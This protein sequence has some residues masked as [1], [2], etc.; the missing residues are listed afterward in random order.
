MELP[1]TLISPSG[2]VEV[3]TTF[4]RANNLMLSHGYKVKP[5]GKPEQAKPVEPA[6]P[7]AKPEVSEK[8][9]SDTRPSALV[10]DDAPQAR[11]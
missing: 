8:P 1:V 6:K 2:L 11:K 5:K 3:V 10:K 4:E 9:S 7:E